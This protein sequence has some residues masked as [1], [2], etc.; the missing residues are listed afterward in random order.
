MTRRIRAYPVGTLP[1]PGWEAF[2]GVNDQEF[3]D[4]VFYV[5]IVDD[6]ATV[7]LVDAG[8]PVGERDLADLIT[9]CQ[10]VDPRCLFRDVRSLADVLADAELTP[11]DIDTVVLTQPITYHT[12]GLEANLLPRARV[13]IPQAGLL[14]MLI[15]PPGHPAVD[16]YFTESSWAFLRRLAVEGRLI[17]TDGPVDVAPGV[18]MQ[19][20]G[21]HHPGSAS[22][23]ISTDD[24]DVTLLETAFFERNVRDGIPIGIAENAARARAA[25][26]EA[27]ATGARVI[28]LHDPS[29]A[30]LFPAGR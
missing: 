15:D 12:G 22:V 1:I 6:G 7:T 13:V 29:N 21:G 19:T 17:V 28:A 10:A 20:T 16:M 24:G 25:I 26:A 30:T 9:A 3:H 5:W 23:T 27:T 8:L 2:F 4:L 18:R 14:E 11:D